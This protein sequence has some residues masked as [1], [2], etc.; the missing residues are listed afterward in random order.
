MAASSASRTILPTL[1][2]ALRVPSTSRSSSAFL[3]RSRAA[4]ALSAALMH[5]PANST[6]PSPDRSTT[7]CTVVDDPSAS[8]TV[9]SSG[10]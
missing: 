10:S 9:T 2:S 3:A 1:A 5:T 4:S 6:R 7:A 8:S